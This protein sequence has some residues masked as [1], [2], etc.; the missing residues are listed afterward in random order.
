MCR[1]W[2][3]I[4]TALGFSQRG[5]FIPYRYAATLDQAAWHGPYPTIAD[6]FHRQ[7]A[8][9]RA[10]LGLIDRYTDALLALGHEAPPA[11]RFKQDW[12]PK[13]DAAVAYALV[14]AKRPQ[15]I[16]EIGSSH[17][18]RFL[19]RSVCDGGFDCAITAI[20]PQPRAALIC[21]LLSGPRI[22]LVW[23][24]REKGNGQEA[25]ACGAYR[26]AA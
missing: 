8:E 23:T 7:E 25:W 9:F 4:A 11:P 1:A 24:K 18:T 13:L 5:V 14:R 26:Q 15:R 3:G 16:V 10:T 21:R 12:F 6:L 19:A 17:S 20:D 2:R 22:I